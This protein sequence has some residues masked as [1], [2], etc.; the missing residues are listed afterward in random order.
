MEIT[1]GK[2][3]PQ[4]NNKNKEF[5]V[6]I[7]YKNVIISLTRVQVKINVLTITERLL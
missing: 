5:L 6:D 2:I 4:Y 3:F 1:C 7:K